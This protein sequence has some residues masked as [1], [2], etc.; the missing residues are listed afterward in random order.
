M[1]INMDWINILKVRPRKRK[2]MPAPPNIFIGETEDS[3]K[4][5]RRVMGRGMMKDKKT[6]VFI[7]ASKE[8]TPTGKKHKRIL[9]EKIIPEKNTRLG[10]RKA[11]EGEVKQNQK[12]ILDRGIKPK[13]TKTM[14][15]NRCAMCTKMLSARNRFTIDYGKDAKGKQIGLSFCKD[16]AERM[17]KT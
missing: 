13:A 10:S 2:R 12:G 16:C 15:K 4:P 5:R 3:E 6:G 17:Q 1:V 7:E 14:P 8:N 11:K 9:E